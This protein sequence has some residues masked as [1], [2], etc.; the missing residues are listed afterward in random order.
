[1]PFPLFDLHCDTASVMEKKKQGFLQNDLCV[2]LKEAKGFS[3]YVQVMAI[4]TNKHLSDEEG[5]LAFHRIYKHLADDPAIKDRS[6]TFGE[7]YCTDLSRPTLL[8]ALEDAR[9]LCKRL[10]RLDEISH[11]GVKIFTPLWA[12]VN[13]LGGAHDTGV[14][15]SP[16]GKQAIQKALALG[17]IPDISHAS[18]K[19]A[20]EII[21]FAKEAKRPVIASH[22]NAY[23]V[24]A[25]SRNLHKEEL[26][27]IIRLEGLVGL[28]LHRPFVKE[29][30]A[31]LSDLLGHIF[32]FLEAGAED[33]LA[34]G[35]DLD[36]CDPIPEIKKLSDYEK[37]WEALAKENLPEKLI[38]NIFFGNA[39]RFAK[40]YFR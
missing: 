14:G 34:L 19:S 11:L 35:G 18:V 26:D 30:T 10:D 40:A 16:F 4:W 13:C 21:L 7:P 1:M 24:C 33:I 28:N 3:P 31:N 20:K 25:A 6:V 36:G 38:K 9:I 23:D 32:Y 27:E 12:G 2:S 29:E 39:D 15:L 22:S 17:M 37:L 8:L 5:W